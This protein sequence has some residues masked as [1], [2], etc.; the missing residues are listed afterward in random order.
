LFENIVKVAGRLKGRFPFWEEE[1][2]GSVGQ[3]AGVES[4][5]GNFADRATENIPPQDG[6]G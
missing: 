2:P 5:R 4:G 6:L 1:S 3:G